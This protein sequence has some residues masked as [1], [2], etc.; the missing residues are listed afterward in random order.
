MPVG[1]VQFVGNWGL[2]PPGPQQAQ[3][4]V[5]AIVFANTLLDPISLYVLVVARKRAANL[6][7]YA[8]RQLLIP[9]SSYIV[10]SQLSSPACCVSLNQSCEMTDN[11]THP[12]LRDGT[13]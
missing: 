13:E 3:G 10:A 7:I 9:L 2:C 11:N 5:I 1:F 8:E 4:A 6:N 12:P